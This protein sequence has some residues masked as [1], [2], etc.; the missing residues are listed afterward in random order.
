MA[1][2]L[3]ITLP[4]D[5][6]ARSRR[7]FESI[8]FR[9]DEWFCDAGTVCLPI[10]ERTMLVLLAARRFAGYSAAGRGGRCSAGTSREVVLAFSASSRHEVDDMADAA[11][12]NGASALREPDDHGFTYSRSFCDP[13]GH[14]WEIVWM[15]PG[16]IPE[17]G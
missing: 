14:A 5:D 11:L 7:F 3:F 4:V 13:D 2:T 16:A 17:A 8:G 15:N 12:A 10:N 1:S 6:T 9:A